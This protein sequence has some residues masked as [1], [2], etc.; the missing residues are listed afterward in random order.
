MNV[1]VISPGEGTGR[2]V[3]VIVQQR[4]TEISR[5]TAWLTFPPGIS[6]S[7]W[8]FRWV[9]T[10]LCCG[11]ILAFSV[12]W[13]SII[14]F[15]SW[16]RGFIYLTPWDLCGRRSYWNIQQRQWKCSFQNVTSWKHPQKNQ[17]LKSRILHVA[18]QTRYVMISWCGVVCR[19]V[20]SAP[21]VSSAA[22]PDSVWRIGHHPSHSLWGTL[23]AARQPDPGP[24]HQ[25]HLLGLWFVHSSAGHPR[26]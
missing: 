23:S 18:C 20:T 22:L 10:S 1:S 11:L 5:R 4:R 17:I 15:H 12:I 13:I 21:L 19:G 2:L 7:S 24:P 9:S 8:P 6:A 14:G 26:R 25:H 3:G 16:D